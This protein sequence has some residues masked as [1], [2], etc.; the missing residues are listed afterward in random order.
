MKVFD[1]DGFLTRV[2]L[3]GTRKELEVAVRFGFIDAPELSQPGG[4]EAQQFL[5]RLIGKQWVTTEAKVQ[6]LL[7]EMRR[8]EVLPEMRC[9][10]HKHERKWNAFAVISGALIIE[11]EREGCGLTQT[12]LRAGDVTAV[13]PG[14]F[15]RFVSGDPVAPLRPRS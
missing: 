13:R 8:L 5:S 15:H 14:E 4:R 12:V 2:A 11:V 1:G 6:T 10:M 3:P 7:F 9:S